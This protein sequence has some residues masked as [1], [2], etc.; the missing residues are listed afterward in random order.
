MSEKTF[1]PVRYRRLLR[2]PARHLPKLI[3][4]LI[5]MSAMARLEVLKPWPM[6][7]LIDHVLKSQQLPQSLQW[8]RLL[9]GA[10]TRDG[11]LLWS[12]LG[13]VL[14][15]VLLQSLTLARSYARVAFN[16]RLNYT[17]AADVLSQLQR[18]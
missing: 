15:F 10:S 11:L 12:L 1:S 14:V 8:L 4:L 16:E 6:K 13:T 2:Y 3:A 5:A 9:P 17:L 18:L 7:I